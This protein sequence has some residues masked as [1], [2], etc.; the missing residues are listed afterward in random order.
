MERIFQ[1]ESISEKEKEKILKK[2]DP[3]KIMAFSRG[4]E[5]T[6]AEK[7]EELALDASEI[8]EG[9]DITVDDAEEARKL[10]LESLSIDPECLWAYIPM[11][12]VTPQEKICN[13][14]ID[15]GIK[16]GEKKFGGDFEKEWE[17]EFYQKISTRPYI[18]L[19][20]A[21]ILNHWKNF[22][23]RKGIADAEK[24]LR[25]NHNDNMG[26]RNLLQLMYLYS[27]RL[28][29]FYANW[30]KYEKDNNTAH[31]YNEALYWYKVNGD[32]DDADEAMEEA[33]EFNPFVLD[34]LTRR[35]KLSDFGNYF[36]HF[37]PRDQNGAIDYCHV[38]L[39]VWWNTPGIQH[40][41]KKF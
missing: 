19:L 8:L 13:Q 9:N 34:F 17:G 36:S 32:T 10:I 3:E 35:K 7:A 23:V 22:E 2:S 26:I 11:I 38:A 29:D 21:R 1:D 4:K 40:W 31:R 6:N 15:R 27:N 30:E 28:D 39:K 33:L 20:H 24:V 14:L 12:Q 41:L 5:L 18:R 37:N 16:I 25:L